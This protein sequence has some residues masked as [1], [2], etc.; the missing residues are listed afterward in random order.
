MR[1]LSILLYGDIDL[2]FMDGSAVWLISMAQMLTI[3][4]NVE[5]DL[6]LK[7]NEKNKHLIQSVKK[8][9]NIN[10]IPASEAMNSNSSNRL[11]VTEA[12][13]F[14]RSLEKRKKYN[15]VI[16]RGFELVLEV[17]KYEEFKDITVPYLTD[18][19]HD[20]RST[21]KERENLKKV[22]HHFNFMFLQTNETKR[23]LKKL[24]NVTGDKIRIL[25]PMIPEPIKQPDFRNKHYRLIYSGKF[26][27]D[28]YTEEIIKASKKL[29]LLDNRIQTKFVG[30]KFQDVLREKENQIRIKR[31]LEETE[32]IDWV[33][34]VSREKCQ[35]LIE[36]SDIGISWRSAFLDNDNSVELSSK[37]L[38]YGRL[39]KPAIVRRTKMHEELLGK[40]YELFV[41]TEEEVIDK[42]LNIFQN[43]DLYYEAAQK[44]YNASLQ[45]TFRAVYE[46]LSDFFWSFK[47]E[48][49]KIV[50]AGHDLK[51]AQMIINYF[52]NLEEF[53]VKIDKFSSHEKHDVNYSRECVDWADI[54]FC[55]WGLGNVVWYSNNKKENQILITRLHFQEKDLKFL[56]MVDFKKVD[57]FIVITPYMLEEFHRI[58]KIPKHQLNYLDNLIDAKQLNLPKTN[59]SQFNIGICG[60]LPARK[61]LDIAIDLFEALWEKDHRYKLFIKGKRPEEVSWLMARKSERSYYESVMDRIEKAPWKKN[62]QFDGHGSDIP[63]WLQK[64]GYL[65][66]PSDYE[67]SHVAVSEAIASG[68][69]P[70]I[71]NWKGANTVYSEKYIVS[72]LDLAL[73]KVVNSDWSEEAVLARKKE[74]FDKFDKKKILKQIEKILIYS[75]TKKYK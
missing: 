70:I 13:K 51:F 74:A 1:K 58:F 45:Y 12:V 33:G 15:L 54:I 24:I 27:K 29:T 38:E 72:S 21:K 57:K 65:V 55:E 71:R 35:E 50:F 8:I 30:D 36:S 53:E 64:I 68:A 22:Y 66:S 14:M 43:E 37:L 67:G 23:A 41:D 11:T 59:D 25:T 63:E 48:P 52:E 26:H 31:E 18:F 75:I 10:C 7:A 17:M 32:S 5:V 47:K 28:W 39:G 19:K 73:E 16:V 42:V 44:I 49:I 46:R 9:P 62:V 6:L 40:D 20:E 34:A 60:V 2:N 3:N 56:R 69:I 61:R 4:P